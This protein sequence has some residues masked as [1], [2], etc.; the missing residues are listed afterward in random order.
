VDLKA[1]GDEDADKIIDAIFRQNNALPPDARIGA[2]FQSLVKIA[3]FTGESSLD[4]IPNSVTRLVG[5]LDLLALPDLDEDRVARAQNLFK[6]SGFGVPLVLFCSSLPQCYAVPYGA[7]VLMSSGRLVAN[8]RRRL[9]ETA[10]FVFDVLC[11]DGLVPASVE[12]VKRY[13]AAG[14]IPPG[15][16]LRS[17]RKVRLMHAAMRRLVREDREQIGDA[18]IPVSQFEMLGTLMTFSVVVTDGLR[19]LGLPV[20]EE[21]A[22]DWFLLWRHVG[23]VLGIVEPKGFSLQ[24][25]GDGADFFQHVRDDWSPSPEG[26][27]LARITLEVMSNLLPGTEFDGIGPTLVRHLAGERCAD[28]LS[29]Q[30]ADWTEILVTRSPLLGTILD[31]VVGGVFETA[32]TPLLQQA[33]Y[34]TMEALSRQQREG[35]NVP[36]SIPTDFLDAWRNQFQARFRI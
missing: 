31:R 25:A 22:N 20:S 11:P 29:V 2:L 6:K 30:P 13:T 33:A 17:A 34:G 5:N 16:G 26:S 32:L 24:T 21:E 15:R 10:Q 19:A 18:S 14:R 3:D 12:E 9:I 4:G 8:P 27:T 7:K 28:I 1:Q 35:K 36:F 23:R